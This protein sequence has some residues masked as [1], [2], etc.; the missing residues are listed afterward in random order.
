MANTTGT[1]LPDKITPADLER[2]FQGLQN[3]VRGSV[4]ETK[5]AI[6]AIAGGAGFVLLM[7]FFFLGKRS[8]TKK[9][10]VIEIRRV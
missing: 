5:P 6:A 4:D 10:A 2:K 9:S 1:V 3:D 7:L 8:G